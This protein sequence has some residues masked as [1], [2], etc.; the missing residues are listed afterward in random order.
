[1]PMIDGITNICMSVFKKMMPH[2]HQ[3]SDVYV[4]G[5]DGVLAW[6]EIPSHGTA[7]SSTTYRTVRTDGPSFL[8]VKRCDGCNNFLIRI[9]TPIG[10]APYE[11]D[12]LKALLM[13][14]LKKE[15]YEGGIDEW[16]NSKCNNDKNG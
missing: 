3:W 12:Y 13:Q 16:L 14:C 5:I 2:K 6:H 1:M 9:D 11:V 15:G 10:V 7:F 8:S 4:A